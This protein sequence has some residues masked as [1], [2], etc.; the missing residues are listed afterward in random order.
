MN[1]REMLH[2][3]RDEL[4]RAARR[5]HARSVRVFGSVARGDDSPDSDI[6]LLV[7][8]EPEASLLDLVGLQQDVESLLGR[9]ADIVTVEGVSPL[10]RDRIAAEAQAL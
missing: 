7:E 2:S 8:F 6:D 5:R 9:R 10:L 4:L 1:T 3:R